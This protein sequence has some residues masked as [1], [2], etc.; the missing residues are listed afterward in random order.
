M[1]HSIHSSTPDQPLEPATIAS[2][3]MTIPGQGELNNDTRCRPRGWWKWRSSHVEQIA[4]QLALA[5]YVAD[6][7]YPKRAVHA[8][9]SPKQDEVTRLSDLYTIRDRAADFAIE[10]GVRG[11]VLIFHGFRVSDSGKTAYTNA[12]NNNEWHPPDSDNNVPDDILSTLDSDRNIDGGIWWW[13]RKNTSDWRSHVEWSPHFHALG[14][15][16]DFKENKPDQNDGWVS[17]R[18]RSLT[19]FALYEEAGYRDMVCTAKHLFTHASFTPGDTT[20]VTTTWFADQSHD[21]VAFLADTTQS[22]N[23]SKPTET[24]IQHTVKEL[25]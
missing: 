4:E 10:Q 12:V 16:T 3:V 11:G 8:T 14:L 6:N 15:S 25:I 5:R 22:L 2:T 21:D 23:V 9:I 13:L 24:S 7:G 17:H 20:N 1:T 18:M 19:P